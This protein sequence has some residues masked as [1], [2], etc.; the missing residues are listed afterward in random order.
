MAKYISDECYLVTIA[1]YQAWVDSRGVIVKAD[2]KLEKNYLY[3]PIKEC[4]NKN[5]HI[6]EYKSL[7]KVPYPTFI[8]QEYYEK[9]VKKNPVL[10]KLR[11][12]FDLE[13]F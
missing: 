7:G 4:Y 8:T 12:V 6:Y 5:G 11:A 10:D 1:G 3:R 2:K 13:A 9:M